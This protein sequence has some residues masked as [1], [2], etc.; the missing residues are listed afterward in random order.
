[1]SDYSFVIK[2]AATTAA[3]NADVV[4]LEYVDIVDAPLMEGQGV[5]YLNGTRG[6]LVNSN[7]TTGPGDMEMVTIEIPGGWGNPTS[8]QASAL[9]TLQLN[10]TLIFV[11]DVDTNVRAAYKGYLKSIPPDWNSGVKRDPDSPSIIMIELTARGTYAAWDGHDN[12]IT[13]VDTTQ[14]EWTVADLEIDNS[15]ELGFTS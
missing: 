5:T 13:W 12:L 6:F 2:I 4:R 1:M 10:R 3:A 14:T 7:T 15:G 11:F 8:E 9:R